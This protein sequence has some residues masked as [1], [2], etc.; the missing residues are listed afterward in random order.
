MEEGISKI[1]IF[2]KVADVEIQSCLFDQ[3]FTPI[4]SCKKKSSKKKSFARLK[5]NSE[6]ILENSLILEKKIW[7]K[8]FGKFF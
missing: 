8:F 1:L 5:K 3:N 4:F 2:R 6:K 7:K